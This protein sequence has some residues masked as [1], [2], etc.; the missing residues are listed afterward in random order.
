MDDGEEDG[1]DEGGLEIPLWRVAWGCQAEEIEGGGKETRELEAMEV[2]ID[3]WIKSRNELKGR[4]ETRK[5]GDGGE[6][7]RI[8]EGEAKGYARK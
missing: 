2:K 3:E 5:V 4:E 8:E 1:G 6:E 7:A